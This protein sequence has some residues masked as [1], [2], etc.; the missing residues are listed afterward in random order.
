MNGLATDRRGLVILSLEECERLLGDNTLGR[1]AV[2]ASGEPLVVPILYR[3]IDGAIVFRTEPGEKMDAVWLHSP[4][5]F[6]I[7][8]WD[9]ARQ[10]G[11]SVLVRGRP[12]TVYDDEAVK[13]YDGLGLESWLAPHQSSTWIRIRPT[14]ISGRRIPES[15]EVPP[16]ANPG[17]GE[18]AT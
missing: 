18:W 3:Y 8:G 17:T 9:T 10:T 1:V 6:E 12:E 14:D 11:W 13:A 7:D 4:M 16:V 15:H 2:M 5:A